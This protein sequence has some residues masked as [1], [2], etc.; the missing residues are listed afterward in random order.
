MWLLTEDCFHQ[1]CRKWCEC[2]CKL[3]KIRQPRN[4][5]YANIPSHCLILFL[6]TFGSKNSRKSFWVRCHKLSTPILRQ[7]H[8]WFCPILLKFPWGRREIFIR[9]KSET[10]GYLQSLKPLL[11]ELHHVLWVRT[12]GYLTQYN[13]TYFGI[14]L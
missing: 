6:F 3:I 11:W 8:Q 4:L 13:L 7:F 10:P 9:F 12:T 2:F 5:I 1:Q 14:R